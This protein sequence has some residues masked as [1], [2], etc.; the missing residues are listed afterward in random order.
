[1]KAILLSAVGLC[2]LAAGCASAPEAN[3]HFAPREAAA[4]AAGVLIVSATYGSGTHFA[5]VTERVDE[6]IHQPD[7]EFFARPEWLHA[8]PT[9]GWNKA[10]TIVYEF[11]GR[12]HVFTAGEGGK[13][14]VDLLIRQTDK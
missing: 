8:D 12:R 10:L 9:P 11:K 2:L 14:S 6:L 4:P 5:D 7:V 13:V 1:M 3:H